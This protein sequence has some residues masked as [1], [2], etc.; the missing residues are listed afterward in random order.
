[1]NG[2]RYPQI[3]AAGEVFLKKGKKRATLNGGESK[4]YVNY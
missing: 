4:M 1:M 2:G 3:W